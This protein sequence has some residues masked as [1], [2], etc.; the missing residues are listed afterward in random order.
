MDI[1]TQHDKQVHI[2]KCHIILERLDSQHLYL[3]SKENACQ[4]SVINIDIPQLTINIA[5]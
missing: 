2:F 5:M 4:L 3:R 1:L